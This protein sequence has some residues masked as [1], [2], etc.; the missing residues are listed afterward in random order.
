MAG[1]RRQTASHCSADDAQTAWAPPRRSTNRMRVV[2]STLGQAASA[3][4]HAR[5]HPSEFLSVPM[6]HP[7]LFSQRIAGT[8]VT[9]LRVGYSFILSVIP[10]DNIA[11]MHVRKKKLSD[12]PGDPKAF[13]HNFAGDYFTRHF[14]NRPRSSSTCANVAPISDGVGATRIP[15][16]SMVRIFDSAVPLPPETIAPA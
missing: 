1:R 7:P 15:H 8:K 11:V 10:R 12:L 2:G 14:S 13:F 9:P 6:H 3:M 4:V 5:S 16:A